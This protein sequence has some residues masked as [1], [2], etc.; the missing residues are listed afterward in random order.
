MYSRYVYLLPFAYISATISF[1][2]SPTFI[3]S[4]FLLLLAQMPPCSRIPSHLQNVMMMAAA[5]ALYIV[6]PRGTCFH[7]MQLG[8]MEILCL[9]ARPG[10][11]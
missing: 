5:H 4:E 2:P 10:G 11:V 3:V 9:E 8:I 1:Q 6:T 7:I